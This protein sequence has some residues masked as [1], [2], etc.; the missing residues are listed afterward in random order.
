MLLITNFKDYYDHMAAMGIDKTIPYRRVCNKENHI[1]GNWSDLAF[2]TEGEYKFEYRDYLNHF[3]INRQAIGKV[4]DLPEQA[5][6]SVFNATFGFCG[7]L[8]PVVIIH[9]LRSVAKRKDLVIFK[10]SKNFELLKDIQ[11]KEQGIGYRKSGSSYDNSMLKHCLKE[12]TENEKYFIDLDTPYFLKVGRNYYTNFPI[13]NTDFPKVM[14]ADQAWQQIQ[15]FLTN[16]LKVNERPMIET[17]DK[18][19]IIAAGFDLKTSFRH[20][21]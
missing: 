12:V 14:P 4:L 16:T 21:V 6:D 13:V 8:Y 17:D 19:H 11:S 2:R 9:F 18:Y 15:F 5:I 1:P 3:S 10:D 7:K 20:P